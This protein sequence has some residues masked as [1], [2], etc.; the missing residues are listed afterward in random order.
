VSLRV[1]MLNYE[2]P[3]LGG[4]SAT[5]T[6]GL[7]DQLSRDP[8]FEV[9]LVTSSIAGFRREAYARN[10]TIHHVPIGKSDNLQYQTVREL[11]AYSWQAYSYSRALMSRKRFDLCHAYFGIPCGLIAMFLGLPYLVRLQGA[12]VPGP[13]KRFALMDAVLFKRLSRLV[14]RRARH[15]VANSPG[16]RTRALATSPDQRIRVIANGVDTE[17]FRPAARTW[18]TLRVLSVAR[19]AAGKGLRYLVEALG[20]LRG[21]DV[22]LTLVGSGPE[23]RNLRAL[24]RASGA[25]N[26][27]FAGAVRHEHI[28]EYYR[29]ADVFVLPSLSEGL[30]NAVLEAL[31]CGLPLLLTSAEGTVQLLRDGWNGCV[32]RKRSAADIAECL[33]RYLQDPGTLR[34][35]GGHSREV[36]QSVS[37][38][39]IVD[40]YRRL[41]RQMVRR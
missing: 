9:D 30:S 26:V 20:E 24:A 19:L 17:V 14:W 34:L 3:P 16:L 28:A 22:S 1:L 5:E 2:F 15:V 41:Y 40:S 11:L 32:I 12:D 38:A 4:G 6:Q 37:W 21:E 13:D 10:T 27:T 33:R 25:G 35:H 18:H 39:G 29:Q 8:T 7:L 36:A 31:A 23:E